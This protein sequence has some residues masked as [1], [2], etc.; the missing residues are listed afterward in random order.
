MKELEVVE[1]ALIAIGVINIL[2]PAASLGRLPIDDLNTLAGI[3]AY[4]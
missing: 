2:C 4:T 1:V 3:Y